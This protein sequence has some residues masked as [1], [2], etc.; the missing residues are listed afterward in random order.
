MPSSILDRVKPADIVRDPFPHLV[1]E[2]ALPEDYFGRLAAEY[3][4][5]EAIAGPGELENNIAYIKSASDL[6]AIGASAAWR[7]F[8]AHH[9]S[10]AFYRQAATLWR[11]DVLTFYPDLERHFGK[12]LTDFSVGQRTKRKSG[13]PEAKAHDMKMDC[14]F[15][16]NSPVRVSRSVRGPHVDSQF[17]LFAALLYF[18]REDDDSEGGNLDLYRF[19]TPNPSFERGSFQIDSSQVEKV[20]TVHYAPNTLLM[21]INSP[22]SVHG[23][24]PRSVTNIERRYINF[25]AETYAYNPAGLFTP[26][27]AEA[28]RSSNL[29]SRMRRKLFGR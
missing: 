7:E 26:P 2:N 6:E 15:V 11:D 21:W 10:P 9:C 14:Q 13:D 1:I 8:F 28:P 3:P 27:G 18:R 19:A 20:T 24:S 17:K 25:L 22:R 4:S 16:V 29:L 23:V 5:L 12:P